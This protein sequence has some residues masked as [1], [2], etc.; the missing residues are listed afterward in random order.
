MDQIRAGKFKAKGSVTGLLRDIMRFDGIDC[1]RRKGRWWRYVRRAP[2]A[3]AAIVRF[4]DSHDLED[5]L[6]VIHKCMDTTLGILEQVVLRAYVRLVCDGFA[7]ATG[8]LSL[9]LLTGDV[10]RSIHPQHLSEEEVR[11]LYRKGRDKLRAFL[12]EKGLFP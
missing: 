8:R 2:P 4:D 6:T 5:L 7:T 3:T 10:N 1:L 11:A 12:E 9:R